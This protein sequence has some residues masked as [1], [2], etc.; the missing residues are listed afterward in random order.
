MVN[1]LS[2]VIQNFYYP[3]HS[4]RSTVR[5]RTVVIARNFH[6]IY[7]LFAKSSKAY[8]ILANTNSITRLAYSVGDSRLNAIA[9]AVFSK[10]KFLKYSPIGVNFPMSAHYRTLF[11]INALLEKKRD[12]MPCL[13]LSSN[14]FDYPYYEGSQIVITPIA[15]KPMSY[16]LY[17]FL[18]CSLSLW[19]Y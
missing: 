1:D 8:N 18:R 9:R 14:A 7:S 16:A 12:P 10:V 4:L 6:L 11:N 15:K 2:Y 17:K 3:T 19:F 13:S 5:S